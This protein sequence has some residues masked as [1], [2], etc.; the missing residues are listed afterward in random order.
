MNMASTAMSNRYAGRQQLWLGLGLAVL[1]IAAYAVQF[2]M[3]RLTAPW[4]LPIITTIGTVLIVAA[5]WQQRSI[6][7]V[8]A[9]VL[10][11]LL[12]GAEWTFLLALRHP[13]YSGPAVVGKEFPTFATVR[14]DGTPFTN[15]DLEGDANT[16]FVF[17]RGRW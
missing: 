8:L 5:L 9:L 7:R 12:A 15:R 14:S 4:Y 3:A 16:V 6:W 11:V 10:V 2:L 13:A 1:G 17:F